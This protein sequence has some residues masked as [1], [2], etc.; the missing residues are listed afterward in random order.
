[1]NEFKDYK[2]T[3]NIYHPSKSECGAEKIS[4]EEKEQLLEKGGDPRSA[5]SDSSHSDFYG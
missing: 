2:T 3:E 4:D 5:T 1:M